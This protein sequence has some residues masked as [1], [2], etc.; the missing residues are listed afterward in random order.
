MGKFQILGFFA[1][2]KFYKKFIGTH[3]IL[4][5]GFLCTRFDMDYLE[6]MTKNV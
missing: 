1:F 3:E 4:V 5:V 2:E 6:V